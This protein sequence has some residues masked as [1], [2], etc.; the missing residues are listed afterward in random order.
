[1]LSEEFQKIVDLRRSNR[2]FDS[3][4]EVPEEVI[5]KSIERSILAPNSSNMQLWEFQW[6]QSEDMLKELSALCLNQSAASTAKHMVVFITRKDLWKQRAK[7]NYE[8]IAKTIKGEPNRLQKR[9]LD[10]YKRLIPLVY[11][12]DP[13][14]LLTFL[15]K[16][17]SFFGGLRKPFYRL[18][19]GN[20]QRIVVH[21]SCALAAQ[22][23]MLSIAAEGFHSC[24]MEGFDKYRVK[25]MLK[26]PYGAEVNMIVS[27]GKGTDKGVWGPRYRVPYKEVV[28]KI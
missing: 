12:N 19:G 27:V 3:N 2:S 15:R 5:E 25:R 23:F 16:G 11:M 18:G 26:L 13:F 21:K 4:T 28:K 24:P 7:W 1:M 22:T 10:Y 17:I 14:F 20:E 8:Q 6:V 9:G